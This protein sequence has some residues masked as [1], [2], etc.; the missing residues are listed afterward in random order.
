[1]GNKLLDIGNFKFLFRLA[2]K[3][4]G[5]VFS[6]VDFTEL[7]RASL[8]EK[9]SIIERC[10]SRFP[11]FRELL[12]FYVYEDF[13]RA[14]RIMIPGLIKDDLKW[15]YY[16]EYNLRKIF[17]RFD[18]SRLIK[19]FRK[20]FHDPNNRAQVIAE[21][22]TLSKLS[23]VTKRIDFDVPTSGDS[24][25][26]NFDFQVPIDGRDFNF[27]VTY[28]EDPFP[29]HFPR[30]VSAK[31]KE[32]V[33]IPDHLMVRVS[34]RKLPNINSPAE[35]ESLISTIDF[36]INNYRG[37]GDT[38]ELNGADFLWDSNDLTLYHASGE[39]IVD[40]III[41]ESL[42]YGGNVEFDFGSLSRATV[43]AGWVSEKGA[44]SDFET[45]ESKEIRDK[46][47]TKTKQLPEGGNN[48]FVLFYSGF[49]DFSI[50]AALY[51]DGLVHYSKELKKS[52]FVALPNGLFVQPYFKRISGVIF[53][54]RDPIPISGV[55]F[56]NCNSEP[57]MALNDYYLI[58]SIFY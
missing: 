51:G 17:N 1:M 19:K 53:V 58:C 37:F 2:G 42:E 36:V 29:P 8:K 40:S 3:E 28:R 15:V 30:R 25:G 56:A 24:K 48:F 38:V 13:I 21:I 57:K 34:F 9:I 32:L 16:F 11:F 41:D 20:G 4:P 45:P 23:E 27:E 46:L 7:D 14:G 54:P 26:S 5:E 50:K 52:K 43:E 55:L 10:R 33:K 12:L 31:I 35:L 6:D 49:S 22:F 39:T 44:K 47:S 18:E